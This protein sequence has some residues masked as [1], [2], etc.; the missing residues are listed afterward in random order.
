MGS[1]DREVPLY[2]V[3]LVWEVKIERFHFTV[4]LS[5]SVEPL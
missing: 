3:S 1:P 5:S 2:E 4:T